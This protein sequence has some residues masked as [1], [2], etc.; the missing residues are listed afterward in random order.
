MQILVGQSGRPEG[1]GQRRRHAG[2]LVSVVG[3]DDDDSDGQRRGRPTRICCGHPKSVV[4]SSPAM[5]LAAL[6]VE[7]CPP[8][9]NKKVKTEMEVGAMV[10]DRPGGDEEDPV[11]AAWFEEIVA[12][13]RR[14]DP[15]HCG[16]CGTQVH[17]DDTVEA[18]IPGALVRFDGIAA[19]FEVVVDRVDRVCPACA[20]FARPPREIG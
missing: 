6:T 11:D 2:T 19:P 12:A 7:L 13:A 14:G 18:L 4:T 8:G 10:T 9:R 3:G 17:P 1:V 20:V 16:I 5:N 15:I